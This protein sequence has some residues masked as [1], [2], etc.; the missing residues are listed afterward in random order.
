MELKEQNE[1][2]EGLVNFLEEE[3]I[4]LQSKMEKMMAAGKKPFAPDLLL[5]PLY[6][7]EM[8]AFTDS[9]L[10]KDLVLELE[11]MR[12]KHGVCGRDRSPSRLDA[13]VKSLEQERD[14]Y[15]QEAERYQ[16]AR[17]GLDLSPSRSPSGSRTPSSKAKRVRDYV[18]NVTVKLTQYVNNNILWHW[19]IM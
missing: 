3:K 17:G 16:K 1:K 9:L 8:N 2:M 7:V 6:V 12:V 18:F 11:T 4:R 19:K 14:F 13:F 15:R 5:H 10:E